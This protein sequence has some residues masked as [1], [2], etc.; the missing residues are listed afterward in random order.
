MFERLVARIPAL[1][2]FAALALLVQVT[3]VQDDVARGLVHGVPAALL[4]VA[5]LRAGRGARRTPRR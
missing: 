2:V 5:Y 1:L 3:V 4:L